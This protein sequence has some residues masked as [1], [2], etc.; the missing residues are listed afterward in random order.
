MTTVSATRPGRGA[1]RSTSALASALATVVVGARDRA[2][3]TTR[4]SR[5]S[6][7]RNSSR[8]TPGR[9]VLGS[10]SRRTAKPATPL[11]ARASRYAAR[12]RSASARERRC[13]LPPRPGASRKP[14]CS[15]QRY[16]RAERC[17]GPG[18][19]ERSRCWPEAPTP[20]G[21]AR[22]ADERRVLLADQPE[23]GAVQHPPERRQLGRDRPRRQHVR[24][25]RPPDQ[26]RSGR[27]PSAGRPKVRP[28]SDAAR[29]LAVRPCP[30]G[31]RTPRR[32]RRAAR[33]RR[34]AGGPQRVAETGAELDAP[35]DPRRA[36]GSRSSCSSAGSGPA[37]RLER[38]LRASSCFSSSR[39]SRRRSQNQPGWMWNIGA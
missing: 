15:P 30:P 39:P 3:A 22:I 12:Q 21:G 27:S 10:G 34:R 33:C 9:A 37:S 1:A 26:A 23:A 5:A 35:G 7:L 38:G 36:D 2:S 29:Q 11:A 13:V 8:T 19:R 20:G 32:S 17:A 14:G 18:R 16:F 24:R 6:S 25:L 31:P 4:A 28:R